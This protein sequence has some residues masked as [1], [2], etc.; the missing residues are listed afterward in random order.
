[1][2]LKIITFLVGFFGMGLFYGILLSFFSPESSRTVIIQGAIF[3]GIM[4]GLAEVFVF[5]WIRKR[6]KRKDS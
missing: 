6:F 2:K 5:P 4:W 3:F 1:M